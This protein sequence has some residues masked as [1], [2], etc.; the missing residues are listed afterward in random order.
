MTGTAITSAGGPKL[1]I[2]TRY[3]VAGDEHFVWARGYTQ[4]YDA[5]VSAEWAAALGS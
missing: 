2:G 1:S 3:L 4:L 5:A